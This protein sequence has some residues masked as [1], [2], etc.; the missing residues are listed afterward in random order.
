MSSPLACLLSE[1]GD[2][3]EGEA[4]SDVVFESV[5]AGNITILL[6]IFMTIFHDD[7]SIASRP[8]V[9]GFMT[10]LYIHD[11]TLDSVAMEINSSPDFRCRR[12]IPPRSQTLYH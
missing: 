6:T 12:G 9:T 3:C 11:A 5:V 4:V 7:Q 8:S 1:D 10:S 2:T